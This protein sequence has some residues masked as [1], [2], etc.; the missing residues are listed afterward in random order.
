MKIQCVCD[1]CQSNS[2]RLHIGDRIVFSG[3]LPGRIM[4]ELK[5]LAENAGLRVQGSVGPES[6]LIVT[7]DSEDNSSTVKKAVTAGIRTA[8]PDQF[9][10]QISKMQNNGRY[11][12]DRKI[13]RFNQLQLSGQKIYPIS[14]SEEE[15]K[16][17]NL[18]TSKLGCFLGQQL[19]PSLAAGIYNDESKSSGQVKILESEGIP[20]F[21]I[22]EI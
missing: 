8:S 16:K 19:R 14:L 12:H 7:D 1:A 10:N 9:K 22:N 11:L 20:V 5:Y 3:G 17:L 21:H 6:R 2:F 15:M 4:H 13:Q 18:V